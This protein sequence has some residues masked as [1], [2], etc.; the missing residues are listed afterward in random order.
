MA[1]PF[2]MSREI[3]VKFIKRK[4]AVVTS[5]RL[6]ER[7]KSLLWFAEGYDCT[8]IAGKIGRCR[9]VVA[10]YIRIFEKEGIDRLF[11]IGRGPG[12]KSR[13]SKAQKNKIKKWIDMSPRDMG[14]PFNNWDCKRMAI[15][16]KKKFKITL[17]DEQVRRILHQLGCRMLRPRHKLIQANP[18]V[19][20]KKN[21]KLKGLWLTPEKIKTLSFSTKT[22]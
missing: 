4:I 17:S 22:K 10:N 1:R 5:R 16:I 11:K 21:G 9:Q 8:Y 15:H 19:I 12:R 3:P 2:E 20:A 6:K 13:L 14:Y 7:L 18:D